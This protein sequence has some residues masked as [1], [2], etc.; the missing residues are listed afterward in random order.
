MSIRLDL[1]TPLAGVLSELDALLE[2]PVDL[3][4]IGAEARDILIAELSPELNP[5]ATTDVDLV[6]AVDDWQSYVETFAPLTPFGTR[7]MMFTVA[8]IRVDILPFGSVEE[9]SGTIRPPW[10]NELF[11]VGGMREVFATATPL[12]LPAE[13]RLSCRI[14][15]IA[16]FA[17]LKLQAWVERSRQGITKDA[18]DFGIAMSW[19]VDSDE[20]IESLVNDHASLLRAPTF[21]LHAAEMLERVAEGLAD[22]Y[23]DAAD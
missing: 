15:T 2:H 8:G 7:G 17:A 22:A 9:P 19:L 4:V 1:A 18:G 11:R 16:G 20:A 21:D 13:W 12:A 3:L 5:V 14:P 10:M 6:L 23:L